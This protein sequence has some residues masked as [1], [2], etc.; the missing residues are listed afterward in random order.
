MDQQRVVEQWGNPD[1]FP[2]P[3]GD[4][5][6]SP[7]CEWFVNGYKTGNRSCY[8]VYRRNGGS[9]A[10]DE[11]FRGDSVGDIRIDPAPRWNRTDDAILVPG[12]AEDNTRQMFVI[13]VIEKEVGD[14]K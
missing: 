6:L 9:Y 11:V 13:H 8:T 12:I 4:V 5:A 1:I 10:K 14:E 3:E 7:N 2:D